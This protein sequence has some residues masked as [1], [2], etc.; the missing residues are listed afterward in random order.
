MRVQYFQEYY[1][2][3][4]YAIEQFKQTGGATSGTMGTSTDGAFNASH[5]DKYPKE[6]DDKKKAQLFLCNECHAVLPD[7]ELLI[8][9]LTVAHSWSDV[10]ARAFAGQQ[11]AKDTRALLTEIKEPYGQDSGERK[12]E[13]IESKKF[14]GTEVTG[15]ET[16]RQGDMQRGQK[17]VKPKEKVIGAIGRVI[18]GAITGAI[19]D[20]DDKEKA[21]K[22]QET[23]EG[24]C[25]ECDEWW[26]HTIDCPTRKKNIE[27]NSKNSFGVRYGVKGKDKPEVDTDEVADE[28]NEMLGANENETEK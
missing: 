9:H 15:R 24:Y 26:C 19:D 16:N 20:D 4:G 11:I 28:Y 17:V 27:I 6:E 8:E 3:I 18:G 1:Q 22:K 13:N 23:H 21:D 7:P 2:E 25:Q 14:D 12:E 10:G 5:S